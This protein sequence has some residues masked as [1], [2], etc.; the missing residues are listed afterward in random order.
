LVDQRIDFLNS[1]LSGAQKKKKKKKKKKSSFVSA[2]SGFFFLDMAT[3]LVGT[4]LSVVPPITPLSIWLFHC[5]RLSLTV[6]KYGS[7]ARR[8]VKEKEK[9]EEEEEKIFRWKRRISE[10]ER[11]TCQGGWNDDGKRKKRYKK[12]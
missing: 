7:T 3:S 11:E 5:S 10:R 8:R 6:Y 2:P 9:E 4:A 1:L 12:K